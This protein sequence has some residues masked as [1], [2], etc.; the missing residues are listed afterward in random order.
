MPDRVWWPVRGTDGLYRIYDRTQQPRAWLKAVYLPGIPL[1]TQIDDGTVA[2]TGPADGAFTSSI[3]SPSVVIELLRHLAPE[4]GQ[5]TLEIGTGTG[6]TTALLTHRT[7]DTN[8]TTI[9]I[10]PRL[11]HHAQTRLH[12]LGLHPHLI[13][14][15]GEQGH[16][17]NAPYD[18]ILATA[19]VR[20]IPPAWI[21]QLRPGG[22]LLVPLDSPFGHDLL[23][24]L[25]ADGHG[26]AHGRF[27]APVE[28]MRTRAQRT[29]RSHVGLG[30]PPDASPDQWQYLHVTVGPAGQ[31]IHHH[32]SA[33]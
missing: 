17:P 3:S 1:I 2:P 28:F 32:A 12:A 8:V 15:D 24:R 26:Q 33:P 19:S 10:D 6:Y 5:K 14:G 29:P 20:T 23:L 31:H 27:I 13:T 21:D 4:P 11:A 18:R 30:W 9:E 7:G 22:L 25:E 16:P